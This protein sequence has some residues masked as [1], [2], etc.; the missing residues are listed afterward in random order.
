MVALVF[1]VALA[2]VALEPESRGF[3]PR[4]AAPDA[5]ADTG[6]GRGAR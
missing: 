3:A 2:R 5:S 4:F 6:F 1:M